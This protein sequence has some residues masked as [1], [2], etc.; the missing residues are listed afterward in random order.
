M[1]SPIEI[2]TQNP[3]E[4]LDA[5]ITELPEIT[6]RA[7]SGGSTSRD[8]DRYNNS[9][10]QLREHKDGTRGHL[11]IGREA[12]VHVPKIYQIIFRAP[13]TIIFK[14]EKRQAWKPKRG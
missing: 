11:R 5:V 13:E 2:V 7:L 8:I 6:S 14:S 12:R 9:R 1:R 10:A 3:Q 4:A